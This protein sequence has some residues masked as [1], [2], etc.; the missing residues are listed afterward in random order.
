[1]PAVRLHEGRGSVLPR[2]GRCVPTPSAGPIS[3]RGVILRILVVATTIA[4]V[5]VPSAHAAVWRQVTAPGGAAI[6]QVGLLRTPDGVL[7]VAWH[8]R[9]G[10][11]TED[12]WHTR[13]APDGALGPTTP[14]VTGWA[15][16]LDASLT[17]APGGIRA[18]WGGIRTTDSEE[19]NRELNTAYSTD[20]GQSWALQTG[21]VAPG[22][23]QVYGSDVSATALPDGTPLQAWSGTLGTWVHSGLEPAS[24]N[25]DYQAPLGQYGYFP[26]IASDATGRAMMAWFSSAAGNVGVVAQAIGATG[27][28]AG[29]II[30][31][32]GTDVMVGGGTVSRTPIAARVGGG[33]YVAYGVGYPTAGDVRLWAAGASR[34]RLIA[35]AQGEPAVAVAADPDGRLWVAWSDGAFG[36]KRVLARRSNPAGTRFGATVSAGAVKGAHSVYSLDASATR[37]SLDLLALLGTGTASGG[38]TYV[39][40]VLPGLTLRA[41]PRRLPARA[42]DVTF[43]VTDAGDPVRG[44][45]V[46][47]GGRTGTT[48]AAGRVTLT[49]KGKAK[50]RATARSYRRA[51]L[52]LP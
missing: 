32:P 41:Q 45:T 19:P 39:K 26:G 38:S 52:R 8:N 21:S 6:D 4:C 44:V 16:I 48:N 51:T 35:R 24:P 11:N 18:F 20:G 1:M 9:S 10:P 30:T 29:P 34:S 2:G 14:I 46:K 22:G 31:M 7:H 50:A 40:R 12:L 42:R 43:S 25:V 3:V 37:G 28:P 33:F 49:L 5:A 23:A 27:A 15:G 17:P 47:A 13:I 36:D